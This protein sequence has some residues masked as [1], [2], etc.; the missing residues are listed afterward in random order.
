MKGNGKTI[1]LMATEFTL[2]QMMLDTKDNERMIN[3]MD[4]AENLGQ[5]EQY[6]RE[7]TVKEKSMEK[8]F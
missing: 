4:K 1:R 2:I 5:T 7:N 3:N 6:M 8:E